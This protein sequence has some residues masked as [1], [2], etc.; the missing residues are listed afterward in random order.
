MHCRTGDEASS[1][2]GHGEVGL[3]CVGVQPKVTQITVCCEL[4][5][6]SITWEALVNGDRRRMTCVIAALPHRLSL[7]PSSLLGLL[8]C[9]VPIPSH[10]SQT[11]H[12]HRQR[13]K[14]RERSQETC[15][16]ALGLCA[17]LWFARS[18][19]AENKA[20]DEVR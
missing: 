2:A 3:F 17:M 15:L 14:R 5:I 16:S 10:V 19:N 6:W 9:A 13:G 20:W 18:R 7:N 8:Q 4:L 11:A 12:N 1:F